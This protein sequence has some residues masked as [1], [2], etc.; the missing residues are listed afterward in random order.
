MKRTRYTVGRRADKKEHKRIEEAENRQ[1]AV[2]TVGGWSRRKETSRT[3][4]VAGKEEIRKAAGRTPRK[5]R[6]G[7]KQGEQRGNTGTEGKQKGCIN[8]SK[9]PER[10]ERMHTGKHN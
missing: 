7:R 2:G 8:E 10:T 5:W 4:K 1:K 3:G 6:T 9:K